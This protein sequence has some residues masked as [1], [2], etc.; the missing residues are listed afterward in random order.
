MKANKHL[1]LWSSLAALAVLLWAAVHENFFRDWR[2]T[3][4]EIQARLPS[5]QA[6]AFTI[7]LKQ[8]VSR[9]VGA[10]DRCVSCHVGMAPGESGIEGDRLFGRH[11]DVVHDPASYGC[12]VCHGGQGRATETADAHGTVP[13]W[14]E[15]ML[16]KEYLFAGCGG[17]HT[18]LS[19]SNLTQLEEG[20]A[21][22]EQAD[23][24]ACHKLDG[25]GGTLRPGGAGGQEGP[26]LSR[27][28]A[29]GFKAN[30]Y[31]HHIEQKKK[32]AS[33]PWISAFGELSASE[34]LATDEYLRSRVGAP[35]LSEAKALFHTLGCRG[36]HKVRGVGGDDG[37]DLTAVGNKDPGQVSFAQVEGE[38]TLAN[39]FKKHFRSPAT[40]VHGS[41]MP[42]LGLTEQQI[43]Q[44]TFYVLSLRHRI[45][46]EALWPKDRIRA[47]RFGMR[48]FATDGAT[49]YGTFCAACHGAK[50]EGMR[51]PGFTPFPAIG[52]PDFLRLVSDD[53]LREQIKRGRPGRRMPAWGQQEGGLRDEEIGRLVAYVRNL[54]GAAYEGDPKPRR[55]VQGDAAEGERLFAKA[56]GVCHGERGEGREGP[57]LNNRV[58]LDLAA[59]TYLFKTIR[60]GRKGTS[61]AGFGGGSSV[62]GAMT[63]AEISSI[64]A[65]LRTWEGKK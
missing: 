42:E 26:D 58:F 34:R 24:L 22:F 43:D 18:H 51:Y 45:Y 55:W 65:F 19:V 53:F 3:Q 35:G 23:C 39:W 29:Y 33:G 52:N 7:Q 21:R 4:R 60:N 44:L 1:L 63:D 27:V 54:G 11:P 25:R 20:R 50:G 40:V 56:C 9:E 17:C 64:V 47:E 8:I 37:P 14:P 2:V 41:A 16:S 13:H 10:T 12:T 36:C 28:G 38:R 61:M 46:P 32:A 57:Q 30:W 59:D 31:E 6:D 15:P 5:S 48:E 49:L 62:R